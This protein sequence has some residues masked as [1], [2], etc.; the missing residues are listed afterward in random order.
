MKHKLQILKAYWLVNWHCIHYLTINK[1]NHQ[2]ITVSFCNSYQ[3]KIVC[4]K[5]NCGKI[6]FGEETQSFEDKYATQN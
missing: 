3:S 2:V 6:Y 5:C 1:H 4:I